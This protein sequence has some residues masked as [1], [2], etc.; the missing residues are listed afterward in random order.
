[1][2]SKCDR[3]PGSNPVTRLG[4]YLLMQ[5]RRF[6]NFFFQ[7]PPSW[8]WKW[9]MASEDQ[10]H[11]AFFCIVLCSLKCIVA[12]VRIKSP[13]RLYFVFIFP[14]G[15]ILNVTCVFWDYGLG[16]THNNDVSNQQL[17]S[18]S[19][20]FLITVDSCQPTNWS[21]SLFQN[22][23]DH[24][25]HWSMQCSMN[26]P[27]IRSL[28]LHPKYL[29]ILMSRF[30][31]TLGRIDMSGLHGVC[32]PS[33]V[34]FLCGSHKKRCP[35]VGN[36]AQCS[37]YHRSD[38]LRKRSTYKCTIGPDLPT[39]LVITQSFMI[40]RSSDVHGNLAFAVLQVMDL[41]RGVVRVADTWPTCRPASELCVSA[42]TWR[43]LPCL[44]WVK[45]K[46][47]NQ[48]V[49]CNTKISVY[50]SCKTVKSWNSK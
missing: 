16:K 4:Q 30:F 34:P 45:I 14:Q 18:I 32:L 5:H 47:E 1:M 31:F 36:S 28:K 39:F 24:F 40:S 20:K 42:T 33:Y 23:F 10:E 13:S 9:Q 8:S 7:L 22:N 12:L 49:V 15:D 17:F 48:S 2:S 44:W 35:F 3:L 43:T 25:P 6:H 46:W 11:Q 27:L 29:R 38:L 37:I 50:A 21:Q 26:F 41:V 19:W